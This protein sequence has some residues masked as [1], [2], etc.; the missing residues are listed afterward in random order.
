M[1]VT[2]RLSF[3]EALRPPAGAEGAAVAVDLSPADTVA[4]AKAKIAAALGGRVA[5]AMLLLHFGPVDAVIGA[6]YAGDPGVDEAG[7]TLGQYSALSWIA[8]FPAWPL[9]VRP[10][11]PAPPPPGVAAHTAAALAEGKD[12]EA[13]V[14]AARAQVSEG[15]GGEAARAPQQKKLPPAPRPVLRTPTTPDQ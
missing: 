12:P 7:V 14:A 10:L 6:S 9:G 8:R 2:V 4:G 11:P 5:P 3:C 1:L 13:A 15:G